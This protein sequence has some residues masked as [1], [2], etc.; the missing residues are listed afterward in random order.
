MIYT[1]KEGI[2]FSDVDGTLLFGSHNHGV[3]ALS[4]QQ[5]NLFQVSVPNSSRIYSAF[6]LPQILKGQEY[7]FYLDAQTRELGHRVSNNHSF[8]LNTGSRLSTLKSRCALLDFA[9]WSIL[10]NGG[11][12]IDSNYKLDMEWT[13]YVAKDRNLL[14]DIKKELIGEG[15]NLDIE[16]R[17]T[18]IR[19]REKDNP[20]KSLQDFIPYLISNIPSELSITNNLGHW[21]IF[22]SRAGKWNAA[23]YL[24]EKLGYTL[25]QTI[26]I[27]D[28]KN[29]LPLLENTQTTYVL[30]NAYPEVLEVARAKG[31]YVSSGVLFDGINEI[32]E[33]ILKK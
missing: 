20:T 1:K 32:L 15:W 11:I 10:D 21:D 8:V 19:I 4:Q 13:D 30:G 7:F 28:D 29:D 33:D 6:C 27:G 23:K 5:N 31:W 22:I 16:G 25:E 3:I 18:V 14:E 26:S 17:N 12:I 2:V 24:S 9:S